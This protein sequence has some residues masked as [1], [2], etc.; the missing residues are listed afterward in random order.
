MSTAYQHWR[1]CTRKKRYGSRGAAERALRRTG[2]ER[3]QRG[4]VV[5]Q[6]EFCNGGWHFG[7][8]K[9]SR[10]QWGREPTWPLP[11]EE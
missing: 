6:C 7:H 9:K 1:A 8:Q 2:N 5:Y 10:R 4:L 3:T 11:I